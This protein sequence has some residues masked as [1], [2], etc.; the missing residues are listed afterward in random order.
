[1]DIRG[2]RMKPQKHI[3]YITVEDIQKVANETIGRKLVNKE[4]EK[5]IEQLLDKIQWY[6]PLE[7]LI[8]AVYK[9]R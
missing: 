1:M 7:E 2:L 4:I 9:E 3:Y 8:L 6:E 5:V